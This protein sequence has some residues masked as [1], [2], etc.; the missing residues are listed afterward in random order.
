MPT[1]INNLKYALGAVARPSKYLIHFAQP[2]VVTAY[3]NLGDAYLLCKGTAFPG[4]SLG[5]IEVYNQGRKLL[6]PGDTNFTNQWTLTFYQSEDHAIRRNFLSWMQACDNFQ[7]NI[8]TGD[9]AQVLA[10]MGVS[11][12]DSAGNITATYTFHNVFPSDLSE[13]SAGADQQDT[14]E[15]F[16]VAFTFSDWVVGTEEFDDPGSANNATKNPTAYNGVASNSY[17]N[18]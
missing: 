1:T 8:H 16:D 15:E 6:L 12:L 10:E 5:Q 4:K 13:I 2:S 14:A 7:A 17:G 3:G 18:R 11:Q 9:P